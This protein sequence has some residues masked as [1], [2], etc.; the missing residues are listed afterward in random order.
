ML[1]SR[2]RL[3]RD[4]SHQHIG[5]AH[6][7]RDYMCTRVQCSAMTDAKF[8]PENLRIQRIVYV[9]TM[10]FGLSYIWVTLTSCQFVG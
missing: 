10:D 5:C 7:V 4:S 2:K 6:A 8:S 9:L 3:A 1:S